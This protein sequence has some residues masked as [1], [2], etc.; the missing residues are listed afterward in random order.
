MTRGDLVPGRNTEENA[1]PADTGEA[2]GLPPGKLTITIGYGPSLFDG[3]F[4]LAGKKPALLQELPALPNESLDPQYVGGDIAV[5]ACSDDPIVA[6]HALRDLARIG[7]GTV[8]MRWMQI[9]FGSTAR[10]SAPATPR[11]LLGFKDGTRNIDGADDALMRDHVWIGK[12]S[13]QPWLRDGSFLVARR[14]RMFIENWDRDRLGDQES[15]IGRTKVTGAPL[16]GQHRVRHARLRGARRQRR[17]RDRR[18]RGHPPRESRPQQR[19]PHPAAGVLVH[20]RHR[21]GARHVA[22][23]VVLRG[24]HEVARAVRDAADVC[25]AT[26]TR[27]TSTSSTTGAACSC[28][29][30]ACA[31]GRTGRASS[32]TR[33]YSARSATAAGVRAAARAGKNAMTFA[34]TSAPTAVST[35]ASVGIVDA[36]AMPSPSAIAS[37][38]RVADEQPDR[39]PDDQ[40]DDR[41]RRRLPR[42]RARSVAGGRSPSS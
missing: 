3:R 15:V 4:G 10:S 26:T 29:R 36:G 5:Q 31:T 39:D 2:L 30:P 23:R 35:T 19:H 42:D 7:I 17:P 24:L 18:R 20:R 41:E 12:E 38:H 25:S 14:I 32:S 11:N 16:T 9:G 1:P 27:S 6:F 33:S 13:D 34:S 37:P 8:T 22:R 28:A 40:P 21:P